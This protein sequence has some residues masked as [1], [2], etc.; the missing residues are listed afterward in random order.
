MVMHVYNLLHIAAASM[1]KQLAMHGC[2]D[3]LSPPLN[4]SVMACIQPL[5]NNGHLLW[6]HLLLQEISAIAIHM[7]EGTGLKLSL[8][9]RSLA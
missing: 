3:V 7:Q 2:M 5:L 6:T 9:V 1:Y 8:A 4:L